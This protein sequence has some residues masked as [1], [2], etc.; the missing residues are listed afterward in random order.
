MS[1]PAF[2]VQLMFAVNMIEAPVTLKAY[3]MCAFAA[4][5]F[6]YSQVSFSDRGTLEV[7]GVLYG[8][9]SGYINGV[10]GSQVFI[11]LIEGDG[12]TALTSS[13]NSLIVSILSAGTF[14]GAIIAGDLADFFG[15]RVTILSGMYVYA[16]VNATAVR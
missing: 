15:R 14:F 6:L 11:Q 7:S 12:K 9:D 4:G 3:L 16:L 10:T 5:A 8:Y 2:V 13:H 1:L